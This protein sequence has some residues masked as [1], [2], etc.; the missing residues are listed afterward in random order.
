MCTGIGRSNCAYLARASRD[1]MSGLMVAVHLTVEAGLE[2]ACC[3]AHHNSLR[4]IYMSGCAAMN[5]SY[6]DVPR[7]SGIMHFENRHKHER[8][9]NALARSEQAL[10]RSDAAEIMH[11]G[12]L[13]THEGSAGRRHLWLVRQ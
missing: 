8:S 10:Q 5:S 2:C 12:G 3:A 7:D 4:S 13:I 6:P 11:A 9:R 1:R